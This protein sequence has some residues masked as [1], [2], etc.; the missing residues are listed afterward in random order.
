[1]NLTVPF[2]EVFVINLDRRA[3]RWA[4]IE[5]TCK[6]VGLTPNRVPAVE[7][8]P[9]WQACGYSHVKCVKSAIE[10]NIPWAI[11]LEDDATFDLEGINRFR[12]LLPYLWDNRDK[13]ERFNGGPTF[14]A[15]PFVRIMNKE[16]KLVYARGYCTH[17]N[18]IH[19]GGYDD[20]RKWEPTV[21]QMI[22]AYFMKLETRF[23]TIFNSIA[24]FPHISVQ[25]LGPSD[26]SP[27]EDGTKSD[28][29][30]YF[31]YSEGKIRQCLET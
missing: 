23:R 5:Q 8:S 16:L 6:A 14:P 4:A 29:S 25:A 17:F 31:R 15:D 21:D 28:Y 1:M 19:S 13:W 30:N 9:A 10:G 11:I 3:D 27:T 26:V 12:D 22:D 18:L 2:P 7:M 24:T 20:V